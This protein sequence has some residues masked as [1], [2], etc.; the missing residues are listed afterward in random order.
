MADIQNRI[1]IILRAED[2]VEWLVKDADTITLFSLLRPYP[3]DKM[4]VYKVSSD[5]GNVRNINENLIKEV[6][7]IKTVTRESKNQPSTVF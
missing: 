1:P 4:R 5:V 3:V 2:E 6:G 7:Y